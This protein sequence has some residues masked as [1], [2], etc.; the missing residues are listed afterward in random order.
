MLLRPVV[1]TQTAVQRSLPV[2]AGEEPLVGPKVQ[3]YF[4]EKTER[5]SSKKSQKAH[6]TQAQKKK[7]SSLTETGRISKLHVCDAM[8]WIYSRGSVSRVQVEHR[9]G[10]AFHKKERGDHFPGAVVAQRV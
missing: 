6:K 7:W 1:I 10:R 2:C 9:T 8:Y 3:E 4:H 5:I